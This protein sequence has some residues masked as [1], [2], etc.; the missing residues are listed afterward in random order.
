MRKPMLQSFK[1]VSIK[2]ERGM[3]RTMSSTNE[4]RPLPGLPIDLTGK[5]AFIS[6]VADDNGYGWEIAKSLATADDYTELSESLSSV[7]HSSPGGATIS[8]MYFAY[9]KIILGYMVEV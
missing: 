7:E 6:G 3:P 5:R 4:N 9:E 8:L 2:S 1:T